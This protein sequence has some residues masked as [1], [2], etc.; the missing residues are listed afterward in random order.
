MN[1][2]VLKGRLTK[3]PDYRTIQDG[4]GMTKFTLAV[5]KKY[6]KGEKV[7]YF[8]NC[9]AFGRDAENIQ[10]FFQRGDEIAIQGELQDNNYT[11]KEGRKHYEKQVYVEYWWFCGS[12][13]DRDANR[14]SLQAEEDDFVPTSGIEEELPFN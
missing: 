3:D 7:A 12:G 8:H 2:I 1:V 13:K 4:S 6:Q 11:D 10:K 9:I 14:S 5:D